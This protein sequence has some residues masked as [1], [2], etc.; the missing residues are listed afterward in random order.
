[1]DRSN[2]KD[3]GIKN[4]KNDG[5]DGLRKGEERAAKRKVEDRSVQGCIN[6]LRITRLKE[7]AKDNNR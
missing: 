4:V 1:M 3:G 2:G 6:T 5:K 7:V